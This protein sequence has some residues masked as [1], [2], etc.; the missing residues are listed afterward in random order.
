MAEL[1]ESQFFPHFGHTNIGSWVNSIFVGINQGDG[2]MW[3][4]SCQW[5]VLGT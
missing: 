2:W 5:R 4:K 1:L 3:A